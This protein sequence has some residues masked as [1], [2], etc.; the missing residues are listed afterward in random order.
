MR[1]KTIFRFCDQNPAMPISW[2]NG[3]SYSFVTIKMANV[4]SDQ[5]NLVDALKSVSLR[6]KGGIFEVLRCKNATS[7]VDGMKE[8]FEAF[9]VD[10]WVLNLAIYVEWQDPNDQLSK[11]QHPAVRFRISWFELDL[12][13]EQR[14]LEFCW[15]ADRGFICSSQDEYMMIDQPH[16]YPYIWTNLQQFWSVNK[17]HDL[18]PDITWNLTGA[19]AM[20]EL[21]LV[22]TVDL[23]LILLMD[24]RS[25]VRN[26]SD[27][28]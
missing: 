25:T 21:L 18:H 1:S 28:L 4:N 5:K 12:K 13:W 15:L 17:L 2:D 7:S 8:C 3:E 23:P 27:L 6:D 14:V 16:I 22:L 19:R 10:R 9:D 20:V 24:G 26:H 11:S